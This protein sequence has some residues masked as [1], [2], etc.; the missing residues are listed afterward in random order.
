M[1]MEEGWRGMNSRDWLVLPC[2]HALY[3]LSRTH[4]LGCRTCPCKPFA[5]SGKKK[6]E[7]RKEKGEERREKRETRKLGKSDSDN[8]SDRTVTADGDVS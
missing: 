6:G 7:R 5:S 4:H 8:G 3:A 1:E 2:P